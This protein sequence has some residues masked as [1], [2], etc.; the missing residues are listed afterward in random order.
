MGRDTSVTISRDMSRRMEFMVL[1]VMVIAVVE[2]QQ[3]NH[4]HKKDYKII[5]TNEYEDGIKGV[6]LKNKKQ[7]DRAMKQFV[8]G[9]LGPGE[10]G[11]GI[12]LQDINP[13]VAKEKEDMY[14]AQGFDEYISEHLVSL[15]RSLPDRRDDWCKNNV[16]VDPAYLPS[17]SVIVIFHNEAWS[18]LIRTVYSVINRSPPH[19]L[20][21][22]LLVDDASTLPHLGERLQ[23]MVD[24]MGDKVRLIRQPKRAGLMRTRMVGVMESK[25]QVPTFL[26]SHI[27][28]TEGWLEPLLERVHQNPKAIACPVIEEVNDKTFQY[29]V[30]TRDLVGVFFWNLDFGW[31]AVKRP[32]W[33]PYD[34]PV[35]A[36]GLFSIRKDWFAELGFY[37]EGMEIWGGEQLELSFKTWMCGGKIEIVPCSRVGHIFR[38][39][40]PYKWDS[41]K[42]I[43]EYNYKRVAAVWMDQ[44]AE[45]YWDRLGNTWSS[46]DKNVGDFGNVDD[47]KELRRSLQ[48]Q[49]FGWYLRE[50]MPSLGELHIIGMGEIRNPDYNFCM[51]QQDGEANV[52][53]PVLVFDC[54]GEKG[55]QYWYYRADGR[56]SHDILCITAYNEWEDTEQSALKLSTCETADRWKYDSKLLQLTHEPSGLC[57]RVTRHPL[58]LWLVSCDEGDPH[59]KWYFTRYQEPERD[60]SDGGRIE[61]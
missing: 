23:K 19:L 33:S 3:Y 35:M 30:V 43:P 34:T 36:G 6:H 54:H 42:T 49:D 45:L 14:Q 52:G 7:Q 2:S 15:N 4:M 24:S 60:D 46:Q 37:D 26:D 1:V 9:D 39:F 20:A 41:D 5:L 50:V 44:W 58:K 8:A 31:T 25:S 21:E 10:M 11:T 18:T 32:D 40:S 47:R 16:L 56:L 61:L 13:L 53:L 29:K 17:T 28:A 59:Q 12:E 22:I 27:E 57:V 51:D 38:T 48:C 55:N